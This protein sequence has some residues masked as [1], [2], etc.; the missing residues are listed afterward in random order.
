MREEEG[1]REEGR[2]EG[3]GERVRERR[4]EVRGAGRSNDIV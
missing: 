3:E 2:G 4:E 1:V